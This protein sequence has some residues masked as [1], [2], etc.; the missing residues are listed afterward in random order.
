M[1]TEKREDY[2]NPI[3]GGSVRWRSVQ[4]SDLGSE[5]AW[6]DWQWGG[7]EILGPY[8]SILVPYCY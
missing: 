5:I 2:I 8:I 3:A 1:T 4:S 7:Y 6:D